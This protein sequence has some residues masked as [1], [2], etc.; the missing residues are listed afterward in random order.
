LDGL[1]TIAYV[2]SQVNLE[3]RQLNEGIGT[4]LG[5]NVRNGDKP[6]GRAGIICV[7][8]DGQIVDGKGIL[9]D[10]HPLDLILPMVF[11][12]ALG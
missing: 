1:K 12:I 11:E 4:N 6:D 5:Q 2:S 10:E 8:Q 3:V 7:T 9:G